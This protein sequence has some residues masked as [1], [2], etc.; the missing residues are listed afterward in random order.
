MALVL[1]SFE[2]ARNY[3]ETHSK[4]PEKYKKPGMSITLSRET[5]AGADVIS[6]LLVD[7]FR[8][9][10]E[11]GS[12]DWTVFDKN[13]IS[14]ILS[15]HNLPEHLS[16]FYEEKKRTV[17]QQIVNDLFTGISSYDI[18]KR[19]ASTILQL[20]GRGNVII[21]G[22][23][24]SIITAGRKEVFHV[25]IVA[26]LEQ[27]IEHAMEVYGLDRTAAA[28]FVPEEDIARKTYHKTFY[29]KDIDDPLYYDLIIN[30]GACTYSEA[31]EIIGM[32]VLK[33]GEK[34]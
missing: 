27:R 3:I 34:I 12:L 16:R 26:P 31:A 4:Q 10:Q 25:R 14:K 17:L 2:K 20:T 32:A 13:L 6:R 9:H 33:R 19:T 24:G 29:H 15:D 22:M 1:G 21:V 23:A 5:G 11:K 28:R 7:F 18:T 8:P 30:T